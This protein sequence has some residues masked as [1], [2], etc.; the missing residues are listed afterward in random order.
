M[1]PLNRPTWLSESIAVSPKLRTV[2]PPDFAVLIVRG[3][4]LLQKRSSGGGCRLILIA[5]VGVVR[6][7]HHWSQCWLI[8]DDDSMSCQGNPTIPEICMSKEVW[9]HEG[10]Q[11]SVTSIEHNESLFYSFNYISL[12]PQFSIKNNSEKTCLVFI[13]SDLSH[14]VLRDGKMVACTS[15]WW[16]PALSC[17]VNDKSA[18]KCPSTDF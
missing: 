3:T 15:Q 17:R 13:V 18:F 10:P 1:R 7:A 4:N 5:D 8:F 6:I 2:T 11:Y 16:E 14:E 9:L 12:P